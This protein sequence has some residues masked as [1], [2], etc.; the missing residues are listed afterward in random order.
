MGWNGMEKRLFLSQL[1]LQI[2][3]KLEPTIDVDHPWHLTRICQQNKP[4]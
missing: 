4:K 2:N 1:C 3:V